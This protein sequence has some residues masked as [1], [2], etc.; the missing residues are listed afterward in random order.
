MDAIPDQ[1]VVLGDALVIECEADGYPLPTFTWKKVTDSRVGLI[2]LKIHTIHTCIM[3][4][5]FSLKGKYKLLLDLT[6]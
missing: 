3:L 2:S 1:T 4:R 6:R 5:M